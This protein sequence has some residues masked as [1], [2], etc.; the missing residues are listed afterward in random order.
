M[1]D[2][3]TESRTLRAWAQE[4][5][6]A[7]TYPRRV[8]VTI[9]AASELGG[10]VEVEREA[11]ALRPPRSYDVG[12]YGHAHIWQTVQ[13]VHVDGERAPRMISAERVRPAVTS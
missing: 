8:I 13:R 1:S 5:R 3:T 9:H 11:T 12:R 7:P 10:C 4:E 2:K 6:G